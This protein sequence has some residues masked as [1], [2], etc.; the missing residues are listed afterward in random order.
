MTTQVH[1]NETASVHAPDDSRPL[2]LCSRSFAESPLAAAGDGLPGELR[3]LD[4]GELER[5]LSNRRGRPIVVLLDEALQGTELRV[6]PGHTLRVLALLPA[7]AAATLRERL[8]D[9]LSF[10][11]PPDGD[12]QALAVALRC[13]VRE[14]AAADRCFALEHERRRLAGEITK[15]NRIGIAL[16]A[17][18]DPERL[19]NFI[20]TTARDF[21]SSDAGSLYILERD[22]EGRR[23]LR[24]TSSQ[25]DS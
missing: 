25:N 8:G 15:L 2:V 17:E 9:A 14:A 23:L 18:R 7:P 16:S 1:S 10:I 3:A 22:D 12:P 4:R 24:F 5:A 21:T 13:A 19:L 6:A 20:L 11:L